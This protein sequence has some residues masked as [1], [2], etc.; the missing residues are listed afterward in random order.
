MKRLGKSRK[1]YQKLNHLLIS[2]IGK[3]LSFH[4]I[5]RIGKK[6]EKNNNTIAL[7]IF[8]YHKILNK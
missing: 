6:F 3:T 7:N 4:R 1:E 8:L 5:L 2:I